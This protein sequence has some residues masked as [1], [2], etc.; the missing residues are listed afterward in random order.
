MQILILGNLSLR[1]YQC[2]NKDNTPISR[3]VISIRLLGVRQKLTSRDLNL[4][5]IGMLPLVLIVG[6]I[7]FKVRIGRSSFLLVYRLGLFTS[8]LL[9]L[10]IN[11]LLLLCYYS[12]CQVLQSI[13]RN[14]NLKGK[15]NSQE[16]YYQYKNVD[17]LVAYPYID[18]EDTIVE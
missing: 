9:V 18:I 13:V 15:S 6:S 4:G 1:N 14:S 12:G 3:Q 17:R 7:I 11:I 16:E 8:T 10:A 2:T 5:K